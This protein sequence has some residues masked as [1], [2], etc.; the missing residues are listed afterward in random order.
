MGLP[1]GVAEEGPDRIDGGCRVDENW[2]ML[3][4]RVPRWAESRVRTLLGWPPARIARAAYQRYYALGTHRTAGGAAYFGI[5]TLLP[6]LG[7]A[8]LLLAQLAH[9]D[10]NFLRN[11]RHTLQT[12]LGLTPNVVALLYSAQG[13][14]GLRAFLTLLGVVGLVYA[15]V[16]WIESIE[17]GLRAVWPR[18]SAGYWLR[19]YAN[20]WLTLLVTLPS[21]FLIVL[22]AVFVGRSPYRLLIDSGQRLTHGQQLGL[23]F[24]AL[25][26]TVLLASL[27]CYVAYR[28]IGAAPPSRRVRQAAL[29]AGAGIAL[30][31]SAGA[32]ALPLVL[33]NPY[34]IVL[35]ILAVMLWVSGAV[36][37]MLAMA[38][39]ASVAEVSAPAAARAL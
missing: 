30:L 38:V 36:R 8:Y 5:L 2:R 6:F 37:A 12:S 39:W 11:S 21:V 4:P 34:G 25:I 23:E 31:A 20:R 3:R 28:R 9:A 35:T 16:N 10:P 1:L 27:L 18:P 24:L 26:C 32:I 29:L 19:R 13:T 22:V 33:G 7:L 17:Q 14:A 15:G